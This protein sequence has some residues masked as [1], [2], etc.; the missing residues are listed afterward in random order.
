[1]QSLL[2]KE[3]LTEVKHE[4]EERVGKMLSKKPRLYSYGQ[5]HYGRDNQTFFAKF[6]E[7]RR[8]CK[9]IELDSFVKLK[10]R[11]EN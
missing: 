3:G 8:V 1:M 5:K 4:R 7:L 6:S 11:I 9:Q 2:D 10:K